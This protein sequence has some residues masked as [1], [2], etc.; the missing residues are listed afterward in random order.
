MR[1]KRILPKNRDGLPEERIWALPGNRGRM[2]EKSKAGVMD[3][4]PDKRLFMDEND[5]RG[6]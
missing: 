3:K 2:P 1:K 6:F 5:R 4:K